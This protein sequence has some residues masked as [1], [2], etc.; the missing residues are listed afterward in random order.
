MT[1]QSKGRGKGVRYNTPPCSEILLLP[2]KDQDDNTGEGKGWIP[3][4]VGNDG[5]ETRLKQE[6]QGIRIKTI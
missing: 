6:R 3:E 4:L 1:V 2:R 5:I